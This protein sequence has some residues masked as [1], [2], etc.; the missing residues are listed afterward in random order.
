[1]IKEN[2]VF[3]IGVLGK[4][5]GI[6]GEISFLFESDIFDQDD[7]SF[8][9]LKVDGILVPFFIE[10]YRFKGKEVALIT[11]QDINNEEKALKLQGLEVFFPRASFGQNEENE[12][13][14]VSWDFFIGFKAID[15]NLG[16]L[17]EIKDVDTQTINTLFSISNEDDNEIL[18]PAV[19][20]FILDVD[21]KKKEIYLELPEGII[22]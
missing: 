7:L 11:F 1:M 10:E 15:K 14:I 13:M 4:P 20:E 8:L 22:D 3:R 18:I 2:D 5:H 19:E 21:N 9:I 17:G 6:H 16:L 12:N